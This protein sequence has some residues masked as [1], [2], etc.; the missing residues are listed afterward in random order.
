MPGFRAEIE[1]KSD[2][3]FIHFYSKNSQGGPIST[4]RPQAST[5]LRQS[6]KKTHPTGQNK[7]KNRAKLPFWSFFPLKH[8]INLRPYEIIL[9]KKKIL[10][11]IFESLHI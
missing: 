9:S 6:W 1:S 3:I 8:D 7:K 5:H 10:S 2:W 11:K 4:F